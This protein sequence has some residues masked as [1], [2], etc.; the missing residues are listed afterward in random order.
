MLIFDGEVISSSST[1]MLRPLLCLMSPARLLQLWHPTPS[2]KTSDSAFP[3]GALPTVF[4]GNG[5]MRLGWS[6]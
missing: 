3:V 4:T 1:P 6:G 2:P 5:Y